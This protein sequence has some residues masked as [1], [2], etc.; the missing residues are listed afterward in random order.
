MYG[1]VFLYLESRVQMI[2]EYCS[3]MIPALLLGLPIEATYNSKIQPQLVTKRQAQHRD[4]I[5]MLVETAR[6]E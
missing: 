4:F 3:F 1:T 5:L 6:Q 2:V